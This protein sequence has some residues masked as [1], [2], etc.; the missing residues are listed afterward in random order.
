M[1]NE[2]VTPYAGTVIHQGP[3]KSIVEHYPSR[4]CE[5]LF[6]TLEKT[7]SLADFLSGLFCVFV[8]GKTAVKIDLKQFGA[9]DSL[10]HLIVESDF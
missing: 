4:G 1:T 7:R 8:P 2:T 9:A 5:K 3:H 6:R 10:Y